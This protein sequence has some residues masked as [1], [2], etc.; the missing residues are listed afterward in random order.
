MAF[1]LDFH[2]HWFLC[3]PLFHGSFTMDCVPS[4]RVAFVISRSSIVFIQY[5]STCIFSIPCSP[6]PIC[7]L[8][9]TRSMWP[10]FCNIGR[11]HDETCIVVVRDS[12]HIGNSSWSPVCFLQVWTDVLDGPPAVNCC[13]A[14][15]H[16]FWDLS[17]SFL[18]LSAV[19]VSSVLLCKQ[20][21]LHCFVPHAVYYLSLS[22]SVSTAPKL[23]CLAR[24]WKLAA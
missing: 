3:V 7:L 13:I 19:S 17:A 10:S 11:Y 18:D 1:Y 9:H 4:W 23:H 2:K 5:F 22:I 24:F 21:L 12:H 6:I 8:W 15:L 16:P 20:P 14:A